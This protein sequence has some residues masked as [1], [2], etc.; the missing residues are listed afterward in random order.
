MNKPLERH[1]ATSEGQCRKMEQRFKSEGLDL[2]WVKTEPTGDDT[3]KVWC[4]FDGDDV[5]PEADRW[6]TYQEKNQ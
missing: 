5:D 2:T 1:A 4:V 6:P 3:L